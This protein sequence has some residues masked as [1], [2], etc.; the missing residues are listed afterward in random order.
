MKTKNVYAERKPYGEVSVQ[1]ISA[2]TYNSV[3]NKIEENTLMPGETAY[4][5]TIDFNNIPDLTYGNF[6]GTL[7]VRLATI[8]FHLYVDDLS[9]ITNILALD[10]SMEEMNIGASK[11]GKID[12]QVAKNSYENAISVISSPAINPRDGY[13]RKVAYED[14]DVNGV[15][16]DAIVFYVAVKESVVITEVFSDISFFNKGNIVGDNANTTIQNIVIGRGLT[17]TN[18]TSNMKSYI[19]NLYLSEH[20]GDNSYNIL[21]EHTAVAKGSKTEMLIQPTIIRNGENIENLKV[22][23]AQPGG[24]I[25]E[26]DNW[27]NTVITPGVTFKE[28]KN[29]YVILKNTKVT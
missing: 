17:K 25:V 24:K 5:I 10:A 6:T 20:W 23:L 27:A 4:E 3:M 14:D 8:G 19:R 12:F 11:Y 9:E 22:Y 28:G 2:K 7:G 18:S 29:I 16:S 13:P 1:E 26:I 15:L 21:T